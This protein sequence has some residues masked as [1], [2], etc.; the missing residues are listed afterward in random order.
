MKFRAG[1]ALYAVVGPQRLLPVADSHLLEGMLVWMRASERL[2]PRR[3]PVLGENDVFESRRDGVDD[4]NDF[5]ATGH[6]QRPARAEIVLN[7]GDEE[8]V[9]ECRI[10]L[11]DHSELSLIPASTDSC[12]YAHSSLLSSANSRLSY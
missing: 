3:M 2:V 7:I 12:A 5:V 6:G 4:G 8:D 1:R 9:L 10:Q 11:I